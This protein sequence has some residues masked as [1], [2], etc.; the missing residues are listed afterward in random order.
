M[1][2]VLLAVAWLI[3]ADWAQSEVFHLL[4]AWH[5]LVMTISSILQL[6]SCLEPLA[7]AALHAELHPQLLEV[8]LEQA[9]SGSPQACCQRLAPPQACCQR[10]ALPQ[11]CCQLL[12]LLPCP[13]LDVVQALAQNRS[14]CP[15]P[16]PVL[17]Q[18]SQAL[19][20]PLP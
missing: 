13:S 9:A 8:R 11:A 12:A 5:L 2:R 15:P 6:P 14:Q 17:R 4:L 20:T 7:Y 3:A 10:L 19:E 16:D 1:S 18:A